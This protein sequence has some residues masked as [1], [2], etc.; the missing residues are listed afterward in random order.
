MLPISRLAQGASWE[1]GSKL[2]REDILETLVVIL[3][4]HPTKYVITVDATATIA[5]AITLLHTVSAQIF[6][7]TVG[8]FSVTP[9][10]RLHDIV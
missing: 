6:F 4:H 3:G 2:P 10:R 8:Q 1:L 9:N 5:V 7:S